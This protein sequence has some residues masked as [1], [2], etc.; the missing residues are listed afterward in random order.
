VG[1][2]CKT[3]DTTND[4]MAELLSQVST[5]LEQ[6]AL[7]PP[8]ATLERLGCTRPDINGAGTVTAAGA[9]Y[10]AARFASRPD[11][12]LLAA[13]YLRG[14]DTDTLASMTG[15]V[16]GSVHG[17]H[18]IGKL[19][20]CVQ[21][22]EYLAEVANT[23]AERRTTT[24]PLPSRRPAT[25]R[26]DL[27]SLLI[28]G[29]VSHVREFPDG[30]AATAESFEPL[31]RNVQRAVL[32]LSDGQVVFVDVETAGTRSSASTFSTRSD[33]RP[34][35]IGEYVAPSV[36][37]LTTPSR[38]QESGELV[39]AVLPSANLSRCAAFYAQLLGEDLAIRDRTLRITPWLA[40][41][42]ANHIG[43]ETAADILLTTQD[44]GA[45]IERLRVDPSLRSRNMVVLRDPD[46]RTVRVFQ[47]RPSSA[48]DNRP[49]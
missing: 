24:P 15:A 48:S 34:D 49:T 10:L 5:S 2:F 37:P 20:D 1:L 29:E 31:D 43:G 3:W 46:G 13:A 16:L 25:A 47:V 39:Q 45:A 28:A 26:K 18:W 40:L 33:K 6:G 11:G 19:A 35:L 8:T 36:G 12:G 30:R 14:G 17:T 21:D 9:I 27:R 4:E 44:L 23:S 41:R 22:S 7:S 32:R 38:F 42:E